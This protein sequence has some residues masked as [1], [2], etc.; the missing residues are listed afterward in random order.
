VKQAGFKKFIPFQ[1]YEWELRRTRIIDTDSAHENSR[2][3]SLSLS[4]DLK[5]DGGIILAALKKIS[6]AL[7]TLWPRH[8]FENFAAEFNGN[9]KS[10][11]L[12]NA[13][14]DFM[15]MEMSND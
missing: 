9:S 14:P 5:A 10:I 13:L 4:I 6:T 15:S 2:G 3:S 1:L 8:M 11:R 12:D 7:P